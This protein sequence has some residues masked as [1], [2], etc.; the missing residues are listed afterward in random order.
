[1][2]CAGLSEFEEYVELYEVGFSNRTLEKLLKFPTPRNDSL[3]VGAG[4]FPDSGDN[5]YSRA[6][7]HC[8]HRSRPDKILQLLLL[9][10]L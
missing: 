3:S 4:P 7:V 8:S 2:N 5:S 10:Y 1:M 6:K 9:V